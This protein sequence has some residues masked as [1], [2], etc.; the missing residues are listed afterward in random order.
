MPHM[1]E[2]IGA[3]E[4]ALP[5]LKELTEI[6]YGEFSKKDP[7]LDQ[8]IETIEHTLREYEALKTGHLARS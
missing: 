4:R 7:A 6:Y 1:N 8:L 3:L 2:L 5:H